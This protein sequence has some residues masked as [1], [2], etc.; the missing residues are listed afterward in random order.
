[1][2]DLVDWER[3]EWNMDIIEQTC[4]PVDVARIMKTPIGAHHRRINLCGHFPSMVALL[5]VHAILIYYKIKEGE[6]HV[7]S[8]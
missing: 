7:R 5:C 1:M 8:V 3:G 2:A 6:T 4:W